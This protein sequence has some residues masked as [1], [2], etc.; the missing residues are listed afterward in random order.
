MSPI[1]GGHNTITV[2]MHWISNLSGLGNGTP[3]ISNLIG[4]IDLFAEQWVTLACSV[5]GI[6]DE[7]SEA[8]QYVKHVESGHI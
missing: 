2:D 5:V 7:P 8:K 1:P 6:D 3:V 4:T